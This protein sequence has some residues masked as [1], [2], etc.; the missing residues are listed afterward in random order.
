[1]DE[2]PTPSSSSFLLL[3]PSLTIPASSEALSWV[4]QSVRLWLREDAGIL[5]FPENPNRHSRILFPLPSRLVKKLPPPP[6]WILNFTLR[7]FP[8]LALCV[9]GRKRKGK[10]VSATTDEVEEEEEE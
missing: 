8:P 5:F 6:L 1:M 10:N 2:P 3:F 9:R 4:P 7:Q